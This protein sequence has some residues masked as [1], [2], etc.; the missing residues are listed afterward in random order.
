MANSK[1]ILQKMEITKGSEDTVFAYISSNDY[2]DGKSERFIGNDEA[3]K[4]L[5]TTYRDNYR[6]PDNV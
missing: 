1:Q 4:L 3:N 2:F 5:R 6:M